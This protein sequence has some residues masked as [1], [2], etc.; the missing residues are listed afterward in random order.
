MDIQKITT[1]VTR[2]IRNVSRATGRAIQG[3]SDLAQTASKVFNKFEANNGDNSFYG[4]ATIMSLF[5]L[6]P[7]VTSALKRNPDNKEATKDEIREILSRD[8]P[9][10]V[11]IL[12]GLKSM[13][14][15]IANITTKITGIPMVNKPYKKVLGKDAGSIGDRLKNLGSNI[16]ATIN[17]KGGSMALSST[18]VEKRYSNLPNKESVIKLLDD[19]ENCGGKKESVYGKIK[20]SV[21]T[22][23]NKKIEHNKLSSAS[24]KKEIAEGLQKKKEFFKNLSLDDFAN[25]SKENEEEVITAL[26]NKETNKL[27]FTVNTV[28]ANLKNLALAIEVGFLGFGLPALNQK[29]LKEKYLTEKPVGEQKGETFSPFN[30]KHIKAQEVKLYKNFLK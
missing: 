26:S 14:S 3:K 24:N 15:V 8:I 27:A 9:T 28:N 23:L 29:R 11:I 10:I 5:V 16:L 13:N 7:R 20:E 21:D 22:Y 12:F 30:D 18:D 17:P 6:I 19:V 4:L 2:T 25:L 1:P